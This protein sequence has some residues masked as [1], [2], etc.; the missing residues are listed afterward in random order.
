MDRLG[1]ERVAASDEKRLDTPKRVNVRL[2]HLQCQRSLTRQSLSACADKL[3]ESSM[4]IGTPEDLAQAVRD[5]RRHL[6][7]SQGSLAERVGASRQ[8][9]VALEQAKP[10]V[11]VGLVLKTL[12]ALG[13][14]IDVRDPDYDATPYADA[15][16]AAASQEVD[17]TG[18]G[19]PP[20]RR[21]PTSRR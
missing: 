19:V 13:L 7:V 2:H 14:R 8:W 20:V 4:W 5:R 18:D 16:R 11:E 10:T 9:I 17:R 12:A 3:P 21:L 6:G 1:V 15:L